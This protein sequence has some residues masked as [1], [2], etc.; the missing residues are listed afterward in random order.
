MKYWTISFLDTSNT[1][2][3]YSIFGIN[4]LTTDF[5]KAFMFTSKR[6]ANEHLRTMLELNMFPIQMKAYCLNRTVE[7]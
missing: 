2:Y 3:Y 4:S 7:I 5:D 1:V 6:S